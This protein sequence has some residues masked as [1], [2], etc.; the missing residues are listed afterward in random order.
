MGIVNKIHNKISNQI[1]SIIF[2]VNYLL[3]SIYK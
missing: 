2:D 1:V 3:L